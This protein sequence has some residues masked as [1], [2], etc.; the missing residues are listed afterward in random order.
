MSPDTQLIELVLKTAE[1]PQH[2]DARIA[3]TLERLRAVRDNLCANPCCHRF[4]KAGCR[5]DAWAA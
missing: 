4:C 3:A 1:D 2:K 5:S